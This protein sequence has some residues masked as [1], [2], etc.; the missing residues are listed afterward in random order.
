M[1]GCGIVAIAHDATKSRHELGS[2]SAKL[3]VMMKS[4]FA[5][6]FL[7]FRRERQK[8]FATVVLRAGAMHKASG[9]QTV[10]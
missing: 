5:E 10:H 9:L 2:G 7:T 8:D 1:R 6:N 4:E 3:V